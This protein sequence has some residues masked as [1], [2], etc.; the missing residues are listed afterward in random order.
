MGRY[1]FSL[2]FLLVFVPN[3]W[4]TS[5]QLTINE[6]SFSNENPYISWQEFAPNS[7]LCVFEST[8]EER[9]E[10]IHAILDLNDDIT[11]VLKDTLTD[12]QGGFHEF[13]KEY[14]KGFEVEGAIV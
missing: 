14:Y 10:F 7:R 11:L 8:M 1:C 6:L 4:A 3:T 2:F 12:K 5:C 9:I 13:F